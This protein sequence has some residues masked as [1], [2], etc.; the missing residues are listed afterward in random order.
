MPG[1]VR[2]STGTAI[3]RGSFG[4]LNDAVAAI[5]SD[6]LIDEPPTP[7]LRRSPNDVVHALTALLLAL[8]VW[9]ISRYG[10]SGLAG[11]EK[12]FL[13][14]VHRLPRWVESAL[15]ASAQI[16]AI[17]APVIASI[18]LLARRQFRRVARLWLASLVAA[19]AM[20]LIQH[21]GNA[22][23]EELDVYRS[24]QNIGLES[25]APSAAVIA[26]LAAIVAVESPWCTR[27]W[28]RVLRVS[29]TA[30]IIVRLAAGTALPIDVLQALSI[31]WLIGALLLVVLGSPNRQAKAADVIDAIAK[32]GFH[33]RS[34]VSRQSR[35]FA[36]RSF[37]IVT[38]DEQRLFVKVIADDDRDLT[39]PRRVYRWIRVRDVGGQGPLIARERL[40]EREG[41]AAL[42]AF[43]GD[44][45]TA[46][47]HGVAHPTGDVTMLVFD[48]LP[49]RPLRELDPDEVTE[50]VLD[51]AFAALGAMQR[52]RLAHR[53]IQ[54]RSVLVGDDA[55]VAIVDFD[56]AEVGAGTS[57]MAGDVA[58]MLALTASIVGAERSA[59]A[60]TRT[61]G[62][63]V[64]AA[65][66][67][68]LQ[69]LAISHESRS[70]MAAEGGLDAIAVA[71]RAATG[72]PEVPLA[73]IERFKPR[74][75][76]MIALAVLAI[77]ALA[78]QVTGMTQFWPQLRSANWAW[79]LVAGGLSLLTYVGA[80]LSLQGS[81][82]EPLPFR[83]TMA[84]QVAASF[85]SIAA[86]ANIGG[87]G[88]NLRYLQRRGIDS[89]VASAAAGVNAVAAFAVHLSL[90]IG[91]TFW[92][93]NQTADPF[94]LPS[95]GIVGLVAAIVAV[96]IAV[97]LAIPFTRRIA[98][99]RVVPV[100]H[101]AA[102][103]IAEVA[104][105]PVNVLMLF[106]GAMIVTL[107]NFLALTVSLQAFGGGVAISTIAVVY[108]ASS[109]VAAAAPTPG[110]LGAIEAALIGGLTAAGAPSERALG[111]VL[112]FRLITFWLPI[113]PGW[114]VFIRLQRRR[115]I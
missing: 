106:G 70:G 53:N 73:P 88:L 94:K 69:P 108:L 23:T 45:P 32:L 100:A 54:G 60:A 31:G 7:K 2:G 111:A 36:N 26:G 103:G 41:F 64:V 21:L 62:G 56:R 48:E 65:A 101:R 42:S 77:T 19:E 84:T 107:G 91:F 14:L 104:R 67:P 114:I 49:G 5:D 25:S 85:T 24:L 52:C 29:L 34:V 87:I 39:A 92:V 13:A 81:V 27:R 18:Y 82:P 93:G 11:L 33:A 57:L 51:S 44:V 105:R 58:Q 47:L 35:P 46:R 10:T 22:R 112:V 17:F 102:T 80:A 38:R 55:T 28:R 16:V 12:D 15:V 63:D 78:P 37:R 4:T 30:L 1:P 20:V 75:I 68:R 61:L 115:I 79:A 40:V 113:L 98:R 109:V 43:V 96:F 71:V 74:T 9:L 83:T 76:V 95:L 6:V 86:P 90:L 99:E 72:A 97:T 89:A 3:A 66:L 8:A 110:G 50:A 59:A